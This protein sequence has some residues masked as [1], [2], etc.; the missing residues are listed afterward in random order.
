MDFTKFEFTFDNLESLK[1]SNFKLMNISNVNINLV[2]LIFDNV[3][4]TS[5]PTYFLE[6]LIQLELLVIN[7][8]NIRIIHNYTFKSLISLYH[9]EL[10]NNNIT[11]IEADAFYGLVNLLYLE[12]N[13]N[14]LVELCMDTFNIYNKIVVFEYI[15]IQNN[16]LNIIKSG[17]CFSNYIHKLD[18]S[19]NI[20]NSIEINAFDI[21]LKI[22]KSDINVGTLSTIAETMFGNLRELKND[23]ILNDTI[24]CNCQIFNWNFNNTILILMNIFKHYYIG[25]NQLENISMTCTH[26]KGKYIYIY[27]YIYIIIIFIV[28]TN[29][30]STSIRSH[31]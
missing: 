3:Y 18:L 12:L 23:T 25:C 1:C 5:I 28:I 11:Y 31:F 27:I 7:H 26:I 2:F 10:N 6:H 4:W 21:K 17:L 14:S 19:N 15:E 16:R 30:I 29:S 13:Y 9:L 8:N 20:I 22:L 24:M